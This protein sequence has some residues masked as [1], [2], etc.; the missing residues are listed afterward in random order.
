[1]ELTAATEQKA[2]RRQPQPLESDHNDAGDDDLISNLNDDVLVHVLGFLPTTADVAR[3][4]AVSRRWR[5]LGP[6]VPS[7]NF[8][9]SDENHQERID[10]FIAF[11]N[12]HL[13][14]A[15]AAC[16]QQL[17][18]SFSW[19]QHLDVRHIDAAQVDAWIRFGMQRVSKSFVLAIDHVKR[20]NDE[21]NNG[22]VLGELPRS[23]RLESMVLSV[24]N[25]A[26]RLPATVKFDSMT[27]LSLNGLRLDVG[28]DHRLGRLLSSP[29]CPRLQKLSLTLISG[30]EELRLD[31]G[32]LLELSLQ[33]QRMHSADFCRLKLKTP[34]LRVLQIK[35]CALQALRISAPML[36]ELSYSF[37]NFFYR[38]E[39]ITVG[40]L[41]CMRSL[42]GLELS[43]DR[44]SLQANS[45]SVHL[46]QRS[47]S[48]EC[49]SMHLSFPKRNGGDQNILKDHLNIKLPSLQEIRISQYKGRMYEA[50]LM[51]KLHATV[52]AL[53]RI[54]L[55]F[56]PASIRWSKEGLWKL[57]PQIPFAE[58][59]SWAAASTDH[60]SIDY[61]TF[62]WTLACEEEI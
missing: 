33:A 36:E 37:V 18:I 25:A 40:K 55:C 41:S 62:V 4:C 34:K 58:V 5:R 48:V 53:K 14:A 47:A 9:L 16:V 60:D 17:T 59:G 1:M 3:P 7:H 46:L 15:R 31:A 28:S 26:L 57:L 27:H 56:D 50:S 42:K 19:E 51:K 52:P 30:I 49:L 24:S 35:S 43:Y 6:L 44:E 20:F 2:K 29:C 11:V 13:A 61:G 22:M 8:P 39:R 54:K 38:I 21:N 10:R 32:E 45:C 12:H 23:T